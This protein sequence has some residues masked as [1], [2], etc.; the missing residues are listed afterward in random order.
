MEDII[1]SMKNVCKEFPGVKALQNVSLDIFRGEIHG[2]VGENGAGKS[3]FIKIIGGAYSLTSGEMYMNDE[4]L[5]FNAPLEAQKKG[6]SVVHQELK[7]VDSLSVMENIYLGRWPKTKTG[8]VDWQRLKDDAKK[9]IDAI[10]AS[11]DPEELI[12]N[13]TVAQMQIVEICKVLSTNAQF[14]IMDE[15]SAVLTPSEMD[16]LYSI[17]K[18][19]KADGITI[20]YISHRLEEI[21]DLCDRVTVLRD[22]MKIDTM[23][24]SEVS[25]ADLIEKMVGHELGMEHPKETVPIGETVLSV[26]NLCSGDFLKNISFDLHKGEILGFAG[27]VGAGRTE[28]ARAL[29]GADKGATG[30]IM[31][32][33]KP[34]TPSNVPHAIKSGIGLVSE[35][36]KRE[37][38]VLNLSVKKNLSLVNMKTIL[39]NGIISEQKEFELAEKY[40]N[41]LKI[42]TPSDEQEVTYL[43]GGNQ[44][45]VVIGKWL[46]TDSDVFMVDEPTRGIDIGAKKEI[47]SIMTDLVKQG[48]AILMISSEM[49]ELL[50]MCDRIVVMHEGK[51]TGCLSREEATQEKLLELAIQ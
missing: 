1:I 39:K 23:K 27:L 45:K 36:R 13:L 43:S 50:G 48:K 30:E 3:T 16:T 37:G 34:Y 38:L 5:V 44:Q 29:F 18:K 6:I 7:L 25:K 15:P 42:M 31:L 17:I 41:E 47:Y 24:V 11:L 10:G 33:G 32:K 20:L 12:G 28:V 9:I 2:L 40:I 4:K 19:L 51:I 46:N 22:G 8:T 14:I 49:P 35:D 26:R 21:F